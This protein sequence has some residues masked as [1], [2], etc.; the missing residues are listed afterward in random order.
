M[1]C[2]CKDCA[3]RHGVGSRHYPHWATPGRASTMS[4]CAVPDGAEVIYQG[5]HD[6]SGAGLQRASSLGV[7]LPAATTA[8]G[9]T[10]LRPASCESQLAP[11]FSRELESVRAAFYE[12]DEG[13][14]LVGIRCT[15]APVFDLE[16]YSRAIGVSY[17]L[18]GRQRPR[19]DCSRGTR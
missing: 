16:G 9:E 4:P 19:R 14:T 18:H 5:G 3:V 8:V 12:V 13:L 17:L 15:V 11:A 10:H 2:G 6:L 7:R 1:I